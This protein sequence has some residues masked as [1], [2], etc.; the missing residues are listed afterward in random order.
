MVQYR[1]NYPFKIDT[2]LPVDLLLKD[3]LVI[4][5]YQSYT[6]NILLFKLGSA[7]SQIHSIDSFDS[8][9]HSSSPYV[10][11]RV[12]REEEDQHVYFC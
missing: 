1:N 6:C 8:I 12:A 2:R 5:L 10:A 3:I 11:T 7:F 4:L 9:L